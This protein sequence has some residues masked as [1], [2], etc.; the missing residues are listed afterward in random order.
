VYIFWKL[1]ADV[2]FGGKYG[3]RGKGKC[4]KKEE[5]GEMKKKSKLLGKI[6]KY[7]GREGA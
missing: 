5:R 2:I 4:E 6:G 1:S 3:E 7:I